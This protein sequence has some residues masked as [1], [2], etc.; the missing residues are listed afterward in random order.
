[1]EK[2]APGCER[3]SHSLV[4]GVVE[5]IELDT[6]EARLQHGTP[7][8]VI[9]GPFNGWYESSGR[10]LRRREDVPSPSSEERSCYEEG[11][12]LS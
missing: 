1:M 11:C 12:R 2:A 6:E 8:K 5:F 7:L 4:K 10:S 3:I 9:E